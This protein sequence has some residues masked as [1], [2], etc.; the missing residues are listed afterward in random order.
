MLGSARRYDVSSPS[1]EAQLALFAPYC[2]GRRRE[3][4]LRQALELLP[5]GRFE[6]ARE[7]RD[8]PPHRFVLRWSPAHAPLETCHCEL[9]LDDLPQQPYRFDCSAYQLL[10]WLMQGGSSGGRDLPD[11]FWQ[12]LFL[13]RDSGGSAP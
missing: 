8:A 5:T 1:G 9:Q 3:Q 2:G 11:A 7:L 6:G 10:D 13:E 12:W 4:A